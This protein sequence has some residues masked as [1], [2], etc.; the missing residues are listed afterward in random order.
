MTS[1][2]WKWAFRRL[3]IEIKGRMGETA[4]SNIWEKKDISLGFHTGSLDMML[5]ATG[6]VCGLLP[7]FL[8]LDNYIR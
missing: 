2:D 3:Q 5:Q 1:L 4:L 6:L 7:K 8:N